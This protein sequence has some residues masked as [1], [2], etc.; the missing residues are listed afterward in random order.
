MKLGPETYLGAESQSWGTIQFVP[1]SWK[2]AIIIPRRR[3]GTWQG[4]YVAIW[5]RKW[6]CRMRGRLV[7]RTIM[8]PAA[9]S[10]PLLRG[11][12]S[13]SCTYNISKWL[14]LYQN[15]Q[16]FPISNFLIARFQYVCVPDV[17]GALAV[18]RLSTK[19]YIYVYICIYKKKEFKGKL[20]KKK[21]T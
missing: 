21:V 3:G 17:L 14:V 1:K 16:F 11:A 7:H 12:C 10:F 2:M 18:W 13:R 6:I 19:L 8:I 5:C 4:V 15:L 20:I 9:L